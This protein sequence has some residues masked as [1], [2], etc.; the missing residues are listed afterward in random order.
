M[1]G[2]RRRALPVLTAAA[3]AAL[4]VIVSPKSLDLAAH[5]LR[6]K[7]FEQNGFGLWD[8]WWYGGHHT[9]GYSVLY[10]PVAAAL[11]PQVGAALA[12]VGTAAL[13]EPL[14]RE[15][16]G[17][18][19]WLGSTWFALGTATNLFTGRLAFAFGLLPAVAGVR[20]LVRGRLA[21]ACLLGGLTALCS[22]VSAL[23]GALAGLAHAG[24]GSLDPG[25]RARPCAADRVRA[26]APGLGFAAWSLAPALALSLV[27]PEGG[28]E[29]FSTATLVPLPLLCAAALVLLPRHSPR[30]RVGVAL[31]GIGCIVAYAIPTP[32][33]SNAARLGPLVAGPL[34]ALVWWRRRTLLLAICAP[35][36]MYLMWQAPV[37]DVRDANDNPAVNASY[38]QPLLRFLATRPGPPYRLEIPFTFFHWES[39]Q[40]A[41]RFPLARGWERQLDIKDNALFYSG[42]L[43]AARYHAWLD[44]LAVRYVAL[45]DSR[46]DWSAQSEARLIRAGLPFLRPVFTSRHWQVY[47]VVGAPEIVTGAARL[48]RLGGSSLTLRALRPGKATVRVRW[49]PYWSLSPGAG[50]VEADGDFTRVVLRRAGK[51]ILSPRFALGRIGA[52]SPRCS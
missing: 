34:A 40:V 3:V 7:L 39:Y 29:P 18:A 50:C 45:P 21:L 37:R 14:A 36:L 32:I 16:F 52:R 9:L 6:A 46:L 8:N 28:R 11:T 31:Y 17:P 42:R 13:F 10:P 35:L 27:F 33:G 19:A 51:V 20:A 41:P 24:G 5:L 44:S 1:T 4:Y 38:Y 25:L 2:D 47:E 26:A 30:L 22:P 12:C 43:T 49:T 48:I 23:F 15:R